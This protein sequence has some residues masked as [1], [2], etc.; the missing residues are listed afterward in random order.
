MRGPEYNHDIHV[1]SHKCSFKL[2]LNTYKTYVLH[3][4]NQDRWKGNITMDPT[5]TGWKG[6]DRMHPAQ[7]KDPM[8]TYPLLHKAP[9]HEDA[10]G[11]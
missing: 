5:H 11:S 10:W 9:R 3:V 2:H 1:S 6:M 8:K 4:L 7:G